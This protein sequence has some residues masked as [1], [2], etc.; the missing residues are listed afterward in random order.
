MLEI[1]L[2]LHSIIWIG[3][4]VF[5][6][7]MS[8]GGFPIGN[9]ALPLIV[10]S[11]PA[12]AQATRHA[13]AFM[14]PLLCLMDIGAWLVYHR[15]IQW[16]LLRPLFP[17]MLAGVAMG[18]VFFVFSPAQG[19]GIS[20][21]VLK[22][23]IG[24][25]GLIFSLWHLIQPRIRHYLTQKPPVGITAWI[26]GGM[27]GI[28]STL[29]HAAGPVMQMYL[30]PRNLPKMHF[31]ATTA[32]F[33]MVLNGVKLV[34]F[35]AAGRFTHANLSLALLLLP[36]IPAGV[37]SGYWLVKRTRQ[38]NYVRLIR[39]VLFGASLLLV[40]RAILHK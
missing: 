37:S 5:L 8:K 27:A 35:A 18:T 21:R 2:E 19:A 24:A 29:A 22:G 12:S 34:P 4:S 25:L 1:E 36:L 6:L 28:T 15:H 30:L 33:F 13:V 26:F 38:Q 3:L 7:G 20:D 39:A 31:A 9:V 32:A 23:A 40:M 14:L 16:H 11:W 10:L 17:G